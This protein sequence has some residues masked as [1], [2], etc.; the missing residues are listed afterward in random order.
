MQ[1]NL[2]DVDSQHHT[3]RRQITRTALT[4]ILAKAVM[5]LPTFLIAW[6]ALPHLGSERYGV[7]MTVL[8][9]LGFLSIADL[10][11]GGSLITALSRE[12]GAGNYTKV[13]ELQANGLCISVVMALVITFIG[14]AAYNLNIGSYIFKS[15]IAEV[16]YEAS[17]AVLAFGTLFALTL[18]LTILN[19]IQLGLQ[20]G[21]I[22][23]YWQT[24]GSLL[25]F[26]G[27]ASVAFFDGSVPAIISAM[28]VGT[29]LCG[30]M[31]AYYFYRGNI[32][33]RP[34][35]E[36]ISV[37]GFKS[38]LSDSLFYLV[39]QVIFAISYTVDT[40]IVARFLGAGQASV[41]SLCE[42]VFSIVA[43]A[44]AI[45]TG[46]LWVAYGDALGRSDRQWAISTL[47]IS[48]L[49]IF[50]AACVISS[51]ILVML[52]PMIHL[53]SRGKLIAP[54]SLALVMALWRVIE[55]VGGSVSVFMYAS[56][57]N[58]IVLITGFI[59]AIVSIAL[60]VVLAQSIGFVA[61]PAVSSVCYV[62]L[63]LIP[64]ILYIRN[65]LYQ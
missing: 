60:K 23:N 47:R 15:S 3:R 28:M 9:L 24:A 2:V 1:G 39:L 18:P 35:R 43:V 5:F 61:I 34:D 17:L 45:V 26:I 16:Q 8:S 57:A 44:V 30:L 27:G 42:R 64:S 10:G 14:I 59:T 6:I 50:G 46:P 65:R 12:S 37:M 54:F 36:D 25:N 53:L 56:Q 55:S 51:V 29:I 11:V 62:T 48:T 20:Y 21:H 33:Y 40:L 31:N 4:G 63:C 19:K 52:Q 32:K 41:Y 49:R 58:N 13:R 7:L 38:L 22:S